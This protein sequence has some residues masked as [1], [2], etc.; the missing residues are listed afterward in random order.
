M[1]ARVFTRNSAAMDKID[2]KILSMLSRDG[3]LSFREL[4]DAVRLSSNAAAERYRRLVANGAIRHVRA[5]VNPAAVGRSLEV[6]I[7]VKLRP[8]VSAKRFEAALAKLPQV[9]SAS[10][11]T[12]SFDYAVR[13]ACADRDELMQ[14]TEA[15]RASVGAQE[16]YSRLILRQVELPLP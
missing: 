5:S 3:R 13:V 7:D 6:Q 16:T 10:L 8:D 15:L 12:G 2:L 4:G 11:M 1:L 9:V 14:V